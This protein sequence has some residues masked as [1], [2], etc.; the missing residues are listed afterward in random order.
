MATEVASVMNAEDR[1]ILLMLKNLSRDSGSF[2][3]GILNDSLTRDEQ[4]EFGH[5]LVD[6]AEAIRQRAVGIPTTVE[7]LD[8]SVAQGNE[9]IEVGVV[10]GGV[11]EVRQGGFLDLSAAAGE[12]HA[13]GEWPDEQ[14]DGSHP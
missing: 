5:R 2:A 10:D 8:G 6:L 1:L 14:P 13:Q 4:I 3:V 7:V 11:V 9:V 12:A